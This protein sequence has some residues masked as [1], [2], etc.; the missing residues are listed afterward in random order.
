MFPNIKLQLDVE[1]IRLHFMQAFTEL[2]IDTRKMVNEV[3]EKT[4]TPEYL[5]EAI[6]DAAKSAI[7]QVTSEEVTRFFVYGDGRKVVKKVVVDML[8]KP[9]EEEGM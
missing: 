4:V 2:Q 1:A 3:L 9:S 8:S 5:E 6:K 7:K